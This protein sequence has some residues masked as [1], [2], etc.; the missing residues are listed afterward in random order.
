MG[1]LDRTVLALAR[2][3]RRRDREVPPPVPLPEPGGY[4]APETPALGHTRPYSALT[5]RR[6]GPVTRAVVVVTV[7]VALSAMAFS[8]G[9]GYAGDRVDERVA[10]T[11]AFYEARLQETAAAHDARD[12][13]LAMAEAEHGG[14]YWS[15]QWARLVEDPGLTPC[16]AEEAAGAARIRAEARERSFGSAP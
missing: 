6:R 3:L 1:M 4:E 5:R 16:Y 7:A 12:V 8:A 10:E 13:C 11:E 2:G 14:G 9:A 15:G